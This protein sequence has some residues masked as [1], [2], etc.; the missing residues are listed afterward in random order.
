MNSPSWQHAHFGK[1]YFVYARL[2]P[3]Y[4]DPSHGAEQNHVFL[5]AWRSSLLGIHLV[6]GIKS[7]LTAGIFTKEHIWGVFKS[8]LRKAR[9]QWISSFLNY[10]I[11]FQ[12][13]NLKWSI[14]TSQHLNQ[15]LKKKL[16][17]SIVIFIK[18]W[19]SSSFMAGLSAKI[20]CVV[21]LI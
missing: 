4:L 16:T 14:L 17:S 8:N 13:S 9:K 12:N 10:G 3:R 18:M 20:R 19:N 15:S 5:L 1:F 21:T 11:H 2:T 7:S 6:K